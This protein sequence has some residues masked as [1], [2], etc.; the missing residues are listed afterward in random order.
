MTKMIYED[1]GIRFIMGETLRP[2]GFL[3]TQRAVSICGLRQ[4]MRIL[5]IGCGMGATV[6]FLETKYGIDA[7]GIDPSEKLIRL[8]IDQYNISIENGRG[9]SI[10]YGDNLFDGVF[11]ECTLSLMG[12]Y[13]KTIKETY[14]VLKTGGYFIVSDVYAKR[15][16]FINEL[17]ATEIETCLRG[18][19]DLEALKTTMESYGFGIKVSEDWSS[20]LKQ[21]MVDI[22]FKYG[23]MKKFWNIVSCKNCDE[24]RRKLALCKPGYFFIIGE[25]EG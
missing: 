23:S 19:F 20:L 6:N 22:I 16:E 1:N 10:P 9:E 5:D 15:T 3:L 25:K 24:F 7:Y 2:G 17:K 13:E 11:A 8:G 4:G 12:D 14:R 21:L 18:L